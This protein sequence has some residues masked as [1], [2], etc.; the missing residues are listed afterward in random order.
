[1]EENE[2]VL[3][4]GEQ[5]AADEQP[6]PDAV[7]QVEQKV[8]GKE[9]PKE[10]EGDPPKKEKTQEQR[11]IE[12]LRRRV[13]NL[14][15]QKYEL[16]AAAPQP[17]Q[18]KE[19]PASDDE[20]VTL[21]RAELQKMVAERAEKLAP[22][23]TEQRAEI[24]RRNGIVKSLSKEWGQDEFDAKAAD[25]DAAFEGLTDA[26]G[27]PKPATDAIFDADNPKAV[28]EYLT[29]PDNADEAESIARLSAARAGMAIAKLELKLREA[30]AKAK[31]K[32]SSAAQPI[33]AVKGGGVPSGMPDPTN[34]KAWIAWANAQERA[35]RK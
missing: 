24:E 16:R 22:S 34:T 14:T 29:D 32:P 6:K 2:V 15:R 20:P 33:E 31:P 18:E 8:D 5:P 19:T 21:S 17:T 23:I 28:I 3:P 7:E 4:T 25:L 26:Q 35:E 30:A 11:E 1:M 13:D 10:G 12:R 27:R 9:P